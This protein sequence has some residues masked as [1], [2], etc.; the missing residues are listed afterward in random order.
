M[1]MSALDRHIMGRLVGQVARQPP[2]GAVAIAPGLVEPA[3]VMAGQGQQEP[4]EG[5]RVGPRGGPVPDGGGRRPVAEETIGRPQSRQRPLRCGV[6]PDRCKVGRKNGNGRSVTDRRNRPSVSENAPWRHR[7]A[8]R[9]TSCR[10]SARAV[11]RP[12]R[13]PCGTA[14]PRPDRPERDRV[15]VD[16]PAHARQAKLGSE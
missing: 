2:E 16:G 6:G 15:C 4:V 11:A 7:P 13:R 10:E 14:D 5:R 8:P 9:A 1:V 12:G 3:Q